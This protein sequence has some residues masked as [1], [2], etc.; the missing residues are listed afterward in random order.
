MIPSEPAMDGEMGLSKK[1]RSPSVMAM[2]VKFLNTVTIA[3]EMSPRLMSQH[4][5]RT[6]ARTHHTRSGF[7]CDV[8]QVRVVLSE[9]QG[10][11][12]LGGHQHEH[13]A[14]V[15]RQPGRLYNT[16]ASVARK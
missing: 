6:H 9:E 12:E 5:T 16:Y 3:T 10:I 14:H 13:E 2:V 11:P 8:L 4:T 1:M 15:Q 7:P